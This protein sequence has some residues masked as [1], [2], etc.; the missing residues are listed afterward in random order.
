ML[1]VRKSLKG[2]GVSNHISAILKGMEAAEQKKTPTTPTAAVKLATTVVSAMTAA[3]STTA[4]SPTFSVEPRL[5]TIAL[6]LLIK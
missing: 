2:P 4:V 5:M 1:S 6:L 3:A